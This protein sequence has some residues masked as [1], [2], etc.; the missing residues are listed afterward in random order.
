MALSNASALDYETN[1]SFSLTVSATDGTQADTALLTV[2]LND[3]SEGQGGTLFRIDFGGSEFPTLPGPSPNE[4]AT[5]LMQRQIALIL[6]KRRPKGRKQMWKQRES[7]ASMTPT[8]KVLFRQNPQFVRGIPL[9]RNSF[10]IY[11]PND[12]AHGSGTT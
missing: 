1:P 5:G 12:I 4:K 7:S 2:N 6:K 8:K 10:L 9:V 11:V 3:L